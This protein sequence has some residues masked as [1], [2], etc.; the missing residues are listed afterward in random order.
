MRLLEIK[1]SSV[2][3][4]PTLTVDAMAITPQLEMFRKFYTKKD[5]IIKKDIKNMAKW[6]GEVTKSPPTKDKNGYKNKA[7]Q[8]D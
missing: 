6:I 3:V 8:R 2:G 7:V 1:S 5:R 4:F